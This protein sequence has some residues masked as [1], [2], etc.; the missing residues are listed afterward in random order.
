[1]GNGASAN[2]RKEDDRDFD[3]EDFHAI[4]RLCRLGHFLRNFED[5]RKAVQIAI[6]SNLLDNLELL[7]T[8]GRIKDL[9]PVHIAAASS[10]LDALEILHSAGFKLLTIDSNGRTP[11]HCCCMKRTASMNTCLCISFL[12]I[13]GPDALLIRDNSGS[14]PMHLAVLANNADIVRTLLSHNCSQTILNDAGKTPRALAQ[15]MEAHDVLSVLDEYRTVTPKLKKRITTNTSAPVDTERIM[16]IWSKFFENAMKFTGD[17]NDED[18]DPNPLT[19]ALRKDTTDRYEEKYNERNYSDN[20][21]EQGD[22]FQQAIKEWLSWILCYSFGHDNHNS[23]MSMM[24]EGEEEGEDK[25]ELS[26]HSEGYYAI[27]KDTQISIW[28]SDY[29]SQQEQ[30]GLYSFYENQEYYFKYGEENIPLPVNMIEVVQFGWITF[31]DFNN[32]QSSWMNLHTGKFEYFLPIGRDEISYHMG[33]YSHESVTSEWILP[34]Q[35]PCLSWMIVVC[36]NVPQETYKHSSKHT[37]EKHSTSS[38]DN[39]T[40][41]FY[42]NHFT[43]QSTWTEPINWSSVVASTG[44]WV[45]CTGEEH[46]DSYW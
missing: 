15:D 18:E 19:T 44:G 24:D 10:S 12:C 34:D 42:L 38:V 3:F 26:R 2:Y 43:G 6:R 31:Y 11:L 17:D 35:T 37:E 1:M 9:A 36:R 13:H 45:L 8:F 20:T 5:F 40:H 23:T 32:N 30:Y 39:G 16:L 33:F 7:L 46:D 21:K 22:N 14:T 4:E 29:I 25:H 28:V 41:W 27:H